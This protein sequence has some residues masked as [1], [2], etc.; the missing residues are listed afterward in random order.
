MII[1]NLRLV[2]SCWA[3]SLRHHQYKSLIYI[4]DSCQSL[5]SRTMF[6]LSTRAELSPVR[7]IN[8]LLPVVSRLSVIHGLHSTLPATPV[9]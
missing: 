4:T 2:H 7:G 9:S 8:S 1:V 3:I 6:L 5:V